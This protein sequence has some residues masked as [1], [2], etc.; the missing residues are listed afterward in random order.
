MADEEVPQMSHT[1]LQD[2]YYGAMQSE[3]ADSDDDEDVQD[4][5]AH[6]HSHLLQQQQQRAGDLYA[7]P[8][9]PPVLAEDEG[10]CLCIC[11]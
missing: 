5:L 2:A 1:E 8:Q 11:A 6:L 7:P 9:A 10:M 4:E 3:E